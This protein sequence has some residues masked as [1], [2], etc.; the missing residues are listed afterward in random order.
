MQPTQL[1]IRLGTWRTFERSRFA[2]PGSKMCV[3]VVLDMV[4]GRPE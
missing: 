1:S 4:G 2:P 3:D